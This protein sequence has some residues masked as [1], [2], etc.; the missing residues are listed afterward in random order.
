MQVFY[1]FL[2]IHLWSGA[3]PN[4][5]EDAGR[6]GLAAKPI[7]RPKLLSLIEVLGQAIPQT[8]M[9]YEAIPADAAQLLR[10]SFPDL[11][12]HWMLMPHLCQLIPTGV[13]ENQLRYVLADA[14][15]GVRTVGQNPQDPFDT[16]N[17]AAVTVLAEHPFKGSEGWRMGDS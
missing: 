12:E 3:L 2:S 10:Q 17:V 7:R 1:N 6:V 8:A 4:G 15:E 13:S 11:P 14:A 9:S 5:R 16:A